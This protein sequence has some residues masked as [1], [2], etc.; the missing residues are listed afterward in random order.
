[1]ESVA[2]LNIDVLTGAINPLPR[3]RDAGDDGLWVAFSMESHY[4]DTKTRD[5]GRPVFEMAEY[6]KIMVPGDATSIVFRPV[7]PGDIERFPKHYESFKLGQT[8]VQGTPLKGWPHITPAQVDELAF[9]KVQTVEQL[10][11]ISDGNCQR[12]LGLSEL[13]KKAQDY[14]EQLKSEAPMQ[15]VQAELHK[16]DETI[17]ALMQQLAEAQ[18]A[19]AKI[20]ARDRKRHGPEATEPEAAQGETA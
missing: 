5:N 15:K 10:A 1:M 11:A 13:R 8:Q 19:I 18:K 2:A 17:E 20:N 12:Y 9:F 16:R 3:V 14:L 7:R 6:I 4:S